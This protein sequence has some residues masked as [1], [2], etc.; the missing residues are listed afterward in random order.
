[1]IAGAIHALSQRRE[2]NYV[3]INCAAIPE[4]LL[5]SELFG[6]EKGAFTGAIRN[7]V[8]RVEEADGGTI[9][10]DEIGDMSR[11]LQAKLLR[12]LEDGTFTRVGGNQEL[13]VNVRLI[14]ATNRDIVTAIKSNAFRED[15]FHR[16]NVVQFM[17][18][19]LRERGGD[20]VI[21]AHFFLKQFCRNMGKQI[22]G[23]SKETLRLLEMHHWPGNIR[24]LRNAIERCVILETKNEIQPSSLP[25]FKLEARLRK[26]DHEPT[27][28]VS[29]LED[30][31]AGFERDC[32]MNASAEHQYSLNHTAEYLKI[33]RHSLRY[34]MHRLNIKFEHG[35]DDDTVVPEAQ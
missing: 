14:A 30:L 5:E 35:G 3:R 22:D 23:F 20:V 4:Q 26:N 28:I 19:S 12:F 10:L 29:S 21:L 8:G 11:P 18:P 7:K 15:L 31:V 24:E 32:I 16:L 6:H 25:D 17:P 1:M 9:F 34:R 27:Q 33:S 2:E 13:R